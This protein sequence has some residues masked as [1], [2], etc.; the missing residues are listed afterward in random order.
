MKELVIKLSDFLKKD[1]VEINKCKYT[2]DI[3]YQINI[4]VSFKAIKIADSKVYVKGKVAG[5]IEQ[6]C[7]LCLEVYNHPLEI[8]I[9]INMDVKEGCVDVSEEVRQL[10]L[11]EMPSKPVCNDDCL[12]ICKICGKHNRK[13]YS[14]SCVDE[15]NECSKER[16]KELLN[17]YRRK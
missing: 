1:I 6:Q 11:L 17:K 14:C 2:R 10:I 4:S 16:W 8:P 5:F 9:N 12:G 3:G 7:S 13:D 15:Y